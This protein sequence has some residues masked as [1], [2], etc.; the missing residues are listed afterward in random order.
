M[1][2]RFSFLVV[3]I[4]FIIISSMISSAINNIIDRHKPIIID[5]TEYFQVVDQ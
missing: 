1:K 5:A 4:A 2:E 3:L